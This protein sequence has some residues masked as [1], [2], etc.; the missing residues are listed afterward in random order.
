MYKQNVQEIELKSF[1]SICVETCSREQCYLGL[2]FVIW[3]LGPELF[4]IWFAMPSTW[5]W[6]VK[7]GISFDTAGRYLV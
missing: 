2:G 3:V 6:F 5:V 1:V 7:L 4:A